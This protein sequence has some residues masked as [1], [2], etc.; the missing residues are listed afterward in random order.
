MPDI[1]LFYL[2]FVLIGCAMAIL[3]IWS[4]R[5]L[6]IRVSAVVLLVGLVS[7]NYSAL[8]GLLGYP[9]PLD[10]LESGS[11]DG[12]SIV[13]AASIDEGVAIYLWLRHPDERAPHYYKMAWDK[14]AAQTLKLAMDQSYRENSSVMMQQGFEKSLEKNRKKLFYALPHERLPLKPQP[15]L[16]EYKNPNIA[17]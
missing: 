3:T 12:D 17:I 4:R 13:L 6:L 1:P 15:D 14:E 11:S 9:E 16:F 7:L 2:L 10:S 5:N 8:T